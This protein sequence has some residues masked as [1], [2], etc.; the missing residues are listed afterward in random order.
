M[1][2]IIDL[3]HFEI[4][5]NCDFVKLTI[6]VWKLSEINE[7]SSSPAES[8]QRS[9]LRWHPVLINPSENGKKHDGRSLMGA[10]SDATS[11]RRCERTTLARKRP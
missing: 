10:H 5:V 8:S 4:I 7:S 11:R 9:G 2:V 1:I 6:A 3:L